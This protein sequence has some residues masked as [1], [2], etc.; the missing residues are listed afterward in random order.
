MKSKPTN[1]FWNEFS[2]ALS[3]RAEKRPTGK[4]WRSMEEWIAASGG[5]RSATNVKLSQGHKAGLL[6]K[7]E[8]TRLQDGRL[9][10]AVWY[11]RKGA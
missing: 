3:T 5:C 2:T 9:V 6:D 10:R 1:D 4:G 8:G 11:R 7:F